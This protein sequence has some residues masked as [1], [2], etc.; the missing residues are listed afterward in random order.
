MP[1]TADGIRESAYP[2]HC[3]H[4]MPT[5]PPFEYETTKLLKFMPF[6]SICQWA[7]AKL[8]FAPT[9]TEYSFWWVIPAVS[10]KT[11]SSS[12]SFK[13]VFAWYVVAWAVLAPMRARFVVSRDISWISE[14]AS[15]LRAGVSHCKLLALH[16]LACTQPLRACSP[17]PH[18]VHYF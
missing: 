3:S 14:R 5:Y 4:N 16:A 2:P 1:G 17:L 18:V 15:M 9:A 8:S 11:T 10:L 6:Y 13:T 7:V 12:F